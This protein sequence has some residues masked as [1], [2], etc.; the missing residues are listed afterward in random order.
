MSG[1]GATCY[2]LFASAGEA[3]A[4]GKRLSIERENWWICPAVLG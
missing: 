1:S 4:A 2:G 3:A